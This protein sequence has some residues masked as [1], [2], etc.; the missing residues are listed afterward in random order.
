MT[1]ININEFTSKAVN[2]IKFSDKDVD[3][4]IWQGSRLIM[5]T[6]NTTAYTDFNDI[7]DQKIIIPAKAIELIKKINSDVCDI[8]VDAD[9]NLLVKYNRAKTKFAMSTN[10]FEANIYTE[11]LPKM[12]TIE[13]S[14]IGNIKK[15]TKYC[16][17]KE[18]ISVMHGLYFNGNGKELD[19]VGVDGRRFMVFKNKSCKSK[20]KLLVAKEQIEKILNL[21]AGE[22]EDIK[23]CEISEA[24]ALFKVGLYTIIVPTLAVDKFIDYKTIIKKHSGMAITVNPVEFRNAVERVAITCDKKN[25]IVIEGK[26]NEIQISTTSNKGSGYETV[27]AAGIE[28]EFRRGVNATWF[29]DMLA[30]FSSD[31]DIIVGNGEKTGISVLVENEELKQSVFIYLLPMLIRGA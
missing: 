16:F 27:T 20:M 28:T 1:K 9:N 18:D 22:V 23:C 3:Y 2:L 24:K 13:N 17:D 19:I 8:E 5:Q 12:N 21:A 31:I 26:G 4:L 10:T 7:G 30:N 14:V 29:K 11:K 15:V 6:R 25:C